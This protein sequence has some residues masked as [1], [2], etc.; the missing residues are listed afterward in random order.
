MFLKRKLCIAGVFGGVLFFMI[1][2]HT[3]QKNSLVPEMDEAAHSTART[4]TQTQI[5]TVTEMSQ[6]HLCSCPA[7]I[8]DQGVSEWFDQRFDD[9][10]QPYLSAGVNQID[11][12]S[13]K[14]WLGLQKSS[15]GHIN[16]IIEKMFTVISPP[17]IKQMS[18]PSQCQKCA[19]VGNSGNLLQSKYGAMIDSHSFVFRMNKAKTLGFEQHVGNK[20]THHIMYPE[21]AVDLAP[22]VHLVLLP[23]K[24]RDLEWVTSALSTGEVKSTYMKV[25]ELVQADKDKVMVVNPSFFKY[26]HDRWTEHHGRY[27]STGMLAVVFALHLCDEVSV[28]GYGADSQGNWH[29]YWEDNKY[30]GAF[31]KTGVHSGDFER[32][33]ILKLDA[34]GKIKLYP[35]VESKAG[36]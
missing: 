6:H 9:K 3:I 29:H 35:K 14:W 13:L 4:S 20:T 28:F 8:T 7:C 30:A 23:F 10:Q 17:G 32:D 12:D 25:K 1:V 5:K 33:V 34:E 15:N 22:G 27:P 36:K 11:P 16:E 21:S 18:Q 2:S 24:L 26:T 31:R 19:V